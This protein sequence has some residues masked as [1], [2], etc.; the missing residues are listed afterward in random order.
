L[1]NLSALI[2]A[3]PH[4]E[5]LNKNLSEFKN[6]LLPDGCLIDVKSV[7]DIKEATASGVNFWR[8]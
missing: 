7:L 8:L 4:K 2:L 5:Y 1:K 6:M 3:V